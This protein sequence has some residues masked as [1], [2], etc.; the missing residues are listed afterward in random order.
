MWLPTHFSKEDGSAVRVVSDFT[1]DPI[2]LENED[3]ERFEGKRADWSPLPPD[4]DSVAWA[5]HCTLVFE[6]AAADLREQAISL[7]NLAADLDRDGKDFH[8][9]PHAPPAKDIAA[10]LRM[11]AAKAS[12]EADRWRAATDA[13]VGL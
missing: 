11:A 13:R 6:N 4:Y 3:G 9:G 2:V 5:S 10:V 7:D 1:G 12:N 8:R